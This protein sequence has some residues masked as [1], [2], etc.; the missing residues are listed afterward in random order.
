M[1]RITNAI[2]KTIN[3][4]IHIYAAKNLYGLKQKKKKKKHTN[5]VI[6]STN[7]NYINTHCRKVNLYTA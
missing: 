5:L 2:I 3:C 7:N 1:T 4:F 6:T